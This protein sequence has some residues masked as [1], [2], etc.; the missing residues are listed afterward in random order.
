M[1]IVLVLVP[2][3]CT[4]IAD[5]HF[6]FFCSVQSTNG[7]LLYF[8]YYSLEGAPL[9]LVAAAFASRTETAVPSDT[10]NPLLVPATIVS[11]LTAA[12]RPPTTASW[13]PEVS[14]V[15]NNS[16]HT[17]R[18]SYLIASKQPPASTV[19]RGSHRILTS[20]PSLSCPLA[21]MSRGGESSRVPGIAWPRS[22]LR[23]ICWRC[24]SHLRGYDM[25]PP[26]ARRRSP[27]VGSAE[28]QPAA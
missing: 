2:L 14:I 23:L 8:L 5:L 20:T 3:Y 4:C 28:P 9:Q 24:H 1:F 18:S 7:T 27:P 17:R 6:V 10:R 26:A 19:I 22:A 25:A 11:T 16:L 21:V 15:S 12:S 13:R